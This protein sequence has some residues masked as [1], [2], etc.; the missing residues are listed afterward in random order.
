MDQDKLLVDDVSLW[1][2]Q[3]EEP[4]KNS[5]HY[6]QP[7]TLRGNTGCCVHSQGTDLTYHLYQN[8]NITVD[9]TI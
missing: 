6:D 9:T 5:G 4:G 8:L 7:T 2:G 1:L 3:Q